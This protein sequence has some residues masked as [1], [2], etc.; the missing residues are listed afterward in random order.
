MIVYII[1]IFTV[2]VQVIDCSSGGSM[3]TVSKV[4]NIVALHL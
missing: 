1:I 2:S 4:M 3:R